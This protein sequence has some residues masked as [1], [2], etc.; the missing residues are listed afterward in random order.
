MEHR[1]I[2]LPSGKKANI[3]QELTAGDV[4]DINAIFF[5]AVGK[6]GIAEIEGEVPKVDASVM[7]KMKYALLERAVVS[8]SDAE[9]KQHE[10]SLDTEFFR[11]L[12]PRD[13]AVLEAECNE[14]MKNSTVTKDEK[15]E[16][17]SPT[18][19]ASIQ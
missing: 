11:S 4:D 2:T 8:I 10:G 1:E 13:V 6:F 18:S 5:E 14:T 16:L 17:S 15:K 12:S 9:G 19:S 3:K 7:I